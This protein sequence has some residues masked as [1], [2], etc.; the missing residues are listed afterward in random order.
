MYVYIYVYIYIYLE[1]YRLLPNCLRLRY[2]RWNEKEVKK[3]DNE[4][5]KEGWKIKQK[6]KVFFQVNEGALQRIYLPGDIYD[7]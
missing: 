4:I 1:V 6:E 3:D 2:C 7:S 5:F